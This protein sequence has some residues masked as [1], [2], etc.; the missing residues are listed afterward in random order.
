MDP[1][2]LFLVGVLFLTGCASNLPVEITTPIKGSP[3]I[4][5]VLQNID[6][7]KSK[8]VRWGGSIASIE[9]K[10]DE[11]WLEVVSRDLKRSGRPKSS[12]ETAGRFLVIVSQFLD[13]EIYTK[14]RLITV[15]GELAGS[16]EGKIGEQPYTFPIVNSKT[17]FMWAEYRDP[18]PHHYFHRRYYDPFWDPYWDPY[19]RRRFYYSDPRFWY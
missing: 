16:R 19:W 18:P 15:Y 10:K 7:H 14:G 3:Q 2:K 9:N 11:T 8:Q 13:P 12:D 17:A 6:V 4:S 1:K 5:E